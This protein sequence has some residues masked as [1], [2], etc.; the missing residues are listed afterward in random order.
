MPIANDKQQPEIFRDSDNDT[1]A[2]VTAA[3]EPVVLTPK[4]IFRPSRLLLL[5][6]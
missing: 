2:Q 3:R 5:L 1:N 4:S 6:P